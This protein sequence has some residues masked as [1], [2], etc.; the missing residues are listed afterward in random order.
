MGDEAKEL[1]LKLTTVGAQETQR[2]L[3][4]VADSAEKVS[5]AQ[6]SAVQEAVRLANA[7]AYGDKIKTILGQTAEGGKKAAEGLNELKKSG[8]DLTKV[9]RGLGDA[10]EGGT[11]GILG[12][13]NAV[14]GGVGLFRSLGSVLLGPVGVALGAAAAGIALLGRK[15]KENQAAIEKIFT[16]A[17]AGADKLKASYA[18]IEADGTKSTEAQIAAIDTLI[19][20]YDAL[21]QRIE[22]NDRSIATKAKQDVDLKNAQI[23]RDEQRAL[24]GATSDADRK[25]IATQFSA[26][27]AALDDSVAAA[28]LENAINK[29][30]GTITR[31]EKERSARTSELDAATR[32]A[33]EKRTAADI[34]KEDSAGVIIT[35]GIGSKEAQ[36]AITSAK[37]AAKAAN[38]AEGELKKITAKVTAAL[39]D[40]NAQLAATQAAVQDAA[41]NAQLRQT[42]LQT[43]NLKAANAAQPEIAK[44]TSEAVDA[45]ERQDF[46]ALGQAQTGIATINQTIKQATTRERAQ[47]AKTAELLNDNF[48][49]RDEQQN[50]VIKVLDKTKRQVRN[51]REV[52]Q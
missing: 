26:K 42:K 2:Q 22:K 29:N 23:D 48:K 6:K 50:L 28:D 16:D 15:A 11:R 34:A 9:Y 18:Q 4:A 44:L 47:A 33:R 32:E 30:K 41:F 13:L 1:Q 31:V 19:A 24:G 36:E 17:A 49:A 37:E 27:R 35:K 43:E 8:E 7:P 39:Q 12:G 46:G 10:A 5:D 51:A 25:R 40:L 3:E 45:Q 14:R 20:R 52:A 38:F 21:N